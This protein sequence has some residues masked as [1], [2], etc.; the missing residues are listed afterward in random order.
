[1]TLYIRAH[2]PEIR[3]LIASQIQKHRST[4]SGFDIPIPATTISLTETHY[5][6]NLGISVA[7]M[8]GSNEPYPCLLLPRSSIYKTPFRQ[9][10]SIGL[11]DAGYRG[12]VMAKVDILDWKKDEPEYLRY[13]YG[14][15]LFQICQH[16]F[17]PWKKIELVEELPA[18][19]DNRGVGGFGST[20]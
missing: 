15:K 9:C 14:T 2:T 16:N 12:E 13:D 7:A 17:L 11:I 18:G 8:S 3:E 1:M 10:N 5:S 6:F 20:G 4:D 19:P